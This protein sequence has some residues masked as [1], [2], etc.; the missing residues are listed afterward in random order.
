MSSYE[1][2]LQFNLDVMEKQNKSS[3]EIITWLQWFYEK[4]IENVI[5]N[6]NHVTVQ[7]FADFQKKWEQNFEKYCGESK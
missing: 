6:Y 5:K 1:L 3:E 4:A 7:S 2:A